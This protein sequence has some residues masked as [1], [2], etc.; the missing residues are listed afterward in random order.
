MPI[1][2]T[3]PNNSVQQTSTNVESHAIYAAL[4]GGVIGFITGLI[5]FSGGNVTLF[6]RGISLGFV[7]AILGGVLAIATY[8]FVAIARLGRVN[9]AWGYIRHR[10]NIWTLAL[11]HGLLAF[12]L[13]AL[14]FYV[15]AQS[16]IGAR[17]DV[18]ASSTLTALAAGLACYAV[19]LSAKK[20]NAVRVSVLLAIF[21]VSGTFISMLTA[22]DPQWWYYHFSSLG[23]S[24][25]V[26]AYAFNAT[27]IIAGLVVVALTKYITDD[28][29]KLHTV[30][31]KMNKIRR[32]T[33]QALLASMGIALAFVG[34]FVYDA[35]P[36]IHNISASGMAV[37][38]LLIVLLLPWLMPQFNKAYF[39]ASYL[40]LV[41]L[42][43]AVW[44][45][46]SVQYF[47]LTVFE[48]VAAAIIF[49][50]LIVFVRNMAALLEDTCR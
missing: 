47:N 33:F 8:L 49:T 22:S 31:T 30:H 17:L 1:S 7:V 29:A 35:F 16:F 21:L 46:A 43:I 4:A 3:L 25:G 41:A 9:S 28:F 18:W 26:S 27:L 32:T 37:L 12:L 10:V 23:A 42:A 24:G 13:Y 14:L 2:K 34:A 19:Y 15:V 48:L 38:F 44:L 6:E 20:I 45:F 50:W 40:L 39:L 11:V 5:V 36:L